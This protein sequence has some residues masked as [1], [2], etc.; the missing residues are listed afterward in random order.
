MLGSEEKSG[1]LNSTEMGKK[2]DEIR[3]ISIEK[4]YK[5][6]DSQLKWSGRCLGQDM[7]HI[8][9]KCLELVHFLLGI[10]GFHK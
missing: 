4:S 3:S 2:K 5:G 1:K 8:S 7:D 6:G 10:P 9:A